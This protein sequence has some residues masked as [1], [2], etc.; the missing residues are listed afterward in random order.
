MDCQIWLER[1]VCI[2]E[3]GL[4]QKVWLSDQALSP[5]FLPIITL[6]FSGIFSPSRGSTLLGGR[7]S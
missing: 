4:Q 5:F 7:L 3:G 6:I 2:Q 1:K